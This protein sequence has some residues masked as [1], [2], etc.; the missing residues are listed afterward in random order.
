MFIMLYKI[1]KLKIM[2]KEFLLL[3]NNVHGIHS[4]VENSSTLTAFRLHP[5]FQP[6][7]CINIVQYLSNANPP[8]E[9]VLERMLSEE[10]KKW[11]IV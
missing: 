8:K 3:G 11:Y 1:M 10:P 2:K 6:P 4:S 9:S 7:R 5:C